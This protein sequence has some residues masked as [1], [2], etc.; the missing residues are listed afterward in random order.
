MLARELGPRTAAARG[1]V[2]AFCQR[3]LRAASIPGEEGQVAQAVSSEMQV[4][5]YD[6]VQVDAAGNVI[7]CLRGTRGRSR[8]GDRPTLLLHAHMDIVDP[9]DIGRWVHK[10]YA[11]D[12]SEGYLW[13]R[14]AS[15]TKGA[16]AAQ[17]YG[18]GLLAEAGFRPAGDVY[19]VA[20]V[21]EEVGGLGTRYLLR[22][23][24]PDLAII[25][26]PS[27]NTLRRGH[28]GRFEFVVALRGRSAHAS[29][30]QRG[31]NPLYSLSRFLLALRD[32]PMASDETF[33]PSTVSPTL[34]YV[35][36]QSSNVIPAE[37][38]LHLDW[39]YAPGQ[40][41]DAAHALVQ[42][43]ANEAAEPGIAV[44][45]GLRDMT[46][47]SYTGLED[48]IPSAYYP[49]CTAAD[50]AQLIEAHALLER[51][52]ARPVSVGVWGFTTDGGHLAAAGVKCI[53][54]GPGDEAMAH[55]ADER[56]DLEQLVEATTAYMAL[57]WGFA[58]QPPG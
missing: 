46:A 21:G 6:E 49:F 50:D 37:A 7:G 43:L 38:K 53:G 11:G 2:V 56:L 45:V 4:L 10:P 25:G 58:A 19:V 22:S 57:A 44:H 26:E 30:P 15:D 29:A 51:A 1:R 47:R 33:G 17:V 52:L 27:S 55:V 23:F 34:C 54:F 12:I 36:Q 9:G 18:L 48:T 35:D 40:T 16:L 8:G 14:G 31:L 42:R 41:L 39:R 24:R 20:A 5:G 32:A 13:G 3:L 28:R